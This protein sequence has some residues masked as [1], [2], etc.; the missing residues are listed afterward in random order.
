MYEEDIGWYSSKS[1]ME[2]VRPKEPLQYLFKYWRLSKGVRKPLSFREYCELHIACLFKYPYNRAN[3][4]KVA[5]ICDEVC[6]EMKSM[7]L[8][9]ETQ[10]YFGAVKSKEDDVFNGG[11]T[12]FGS[13]M[14]G[15]HRLDLKSPF[16]LHNEAKDKDTSIGW[17]WA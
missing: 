13:D 17:C 7:L 16:E 4:E 9:E 10:R 5:H 11:K 8:S 14:K 12:S 2:Q 1:K 15:G 3:K 6:K